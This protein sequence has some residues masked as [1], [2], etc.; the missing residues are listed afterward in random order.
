MV[1]PLPLRLREHLGRKG[2]KN[3]RARGRRQSC[4]LAMAFH[5]PVGSPEPIST[6][7]IYLFLKRD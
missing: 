2:T 4:L 1:R 5:A 7:Q 6:N 3:V